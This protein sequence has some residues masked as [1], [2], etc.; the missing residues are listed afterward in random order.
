MNRLAI[1]V[2]A[3]AAGMPTSAAAQRQMTFG[4]VVDGP[5]F[6]NATFRPRLQSEITDLLGS[7]FDAQFP[8]SKY[9][10]ANWTRTGI[11]A[12]LQRLLDD[13]EVDLV[14]TFGAIASQSAAE[15]GPLPKP[16]VAP[17]VLDGELQELP[18]SG[19]ASGVRNLTYVNYPTATRTDLR[20]F[21]E[22]VKF[23]HLA[24]LM[25]RAYLEGIPTMRVGLEQAL[26]EL[27]VEWTI[28]EVGS[29]IDLALGTLPS[30]VDAIFVGFLPR[31]SEADTDRLIQVF[32]NRRLPS[33][34][35][36]GEAW[37]RRGFLTSSATDL[38]G[39]RIA[40][41]AALNVQRILLGEDPA[42]IR[43]HFTRNARISINMATARAV[44]ASPPWAVMTEAVLIDRDRQDI[45]RR[46]NLGSAVREAVARNLDLAAQTYAVAAGAQQVR[47]SKA[48]L[49]P[50]L[51]FGIDARVI[52]ADRAAASFGR[53]P[54]RSLAGSATLV[55]SLYSER[56]WAGYG[57]EQHLQEG[58]VQVHDEV[59]L[60]VILD[61]ATTYL[62]VLRAK[63]VERIVQDN[64]RVSRFNY[65]LSEI[66]RSIGTAAAG[67]VARWES[68]IARSR[69]EVITAN[70]LRNIVEI[71]L[72]RILHRP[73]EEAFLPDEARPEDVR[74]ITN[75]PRLEP[76]LSSQSGFRVFRNFMANEALQ[77]SP[78]LRQFDAV[79]AAQSR[80]LTAASRAYFV[81]D[82]ALLANATNVWSKSGAG[83]DPPP[84]TGIVPN[85]LGWAVG[86]QLSYP[87]FTG[88]ARSASKSQAEL[89]L[90]D[91]KTRR[92][93]TADRV[94]QRVRSAMHRMG[95]SYANIGLARTAG[96]AAQLNL[97]LVT[98]SYSR[99]SASITDLID[100]QNNGLLADLDAANS[101][102]DFLTDVM[103]V[104]RAVGAYTF[105][106][107]REER[108][109][110]L[111]RLDAFAARATN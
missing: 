24:V 31:L 70:S 44:G 6:Y 84:G 60:D 64:L 90:E 43:V 73:L 107:T 92:A 16:V 20:A 36:L 27:G 99:G 54:E 85:D 10:V 28:I 30:D 106:L 38:V 68:E 81:P 8:D 49:L 102:Y 46:I 4:V 94:Q 19:G 97:D 110:F 74:V 89:D 62:T 9:V 88:F 96:V 95:A 105:F 15:F 103:D 21:G 86:L 5:S 75:N 35:V 109:D 91:L 58:R 29:S 111:D 11:D 41:R 47:G 72:N 7:E 77:G 56:S 17:F 108:D 53:E 76:Y 3:L 100:A 25:D 61:A 52:D 93:A 87:I 69:Q 13:P 40:R 83:S 82:L 18:L 79:I 23:E 51:D 66:R 2:A 48:P 33:F 104:E 14:L 71:E 42:N 12:A 22:V 78:E 55:Q 98:D 45:D 63:T 26:S 101:S 32:N 1:L 50:Q 37:V 65:E 57:I 67:E 39:Q 34:T 80:A 59:R